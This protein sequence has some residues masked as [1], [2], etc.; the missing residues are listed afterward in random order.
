MEGECTDAMQKARMIITNKE[1]AQHLESLNRK[2]K[3]GERTRGKKIDDLQKW[4]G[5]KFLQPQMKTEL[6]PLEEQ[7][8]AQ[9]T[10]KSMDHAMWLGMGTD[11]EQLK[12]YVSNVQ[13][14]RDNV[15]DTVIGFSDQIPLWIKKGSEREVYAAWE[16]N[17]HTLKADLR[18]QLLEAFTES[19]KAKPIEEKTGQQTTAS[20][21]A[22]MKARPKPKG[23][24]LKTTSTGQTQLRANRET[25]SERYRITYEARQLLHNYYKPDEK[26]RGSVWKGLVLVQGA[27]ARLDN[28]SEDGK[29]IET[30]TY[31]YKGKTVTHKAGAP[32]GNTL[33]AMREARKKA[34]PNL[35]K[36][37]EV[38]S[39]PAA[40]VDG[41]IMKWCIES[42][43]NAMKQSVWQRDAFAAA[44]TLEAEKA[45][46]AAHQIPTTIAPK[47]TAALQLT[48]TDFARRFKAKCKHKM[49]ERR[50]RGQAELNKKGCRETWKA[51]AL[52]IITAIVEAQ[53]E[54]EEANDEEEW[55]VKGSFRNAMLMYRPNIQTGKLEATVGQEWCKGMEVG[56]TRMQMKEWLEDRMK[57]VTNGKPEPPDWKL[58]TVAKELTDLLEWDYWNPED[59]DK[60]KKII[61]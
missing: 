35:F 1:I 3:A 30:E 6:S 25:Q 50:R 7:V 60:H 45:M 33:K 39:Q 20:S 53:D 54:M 8:R 10:W 13:T 49:D 34:H 55:V 52:D 23:R 58:S 48:D 28:I 38:M 59:E 56:T 14:W 31:K 19:V 27:H 17:G 24:P 37:V 5:I 4:T 12:K 43:A 21:S 40:M 9:L 29:W 44:F 36:R 41:I 18:Q 15:Q 47:L 26:P 42:Q 22:P 57:W 2:G 46:Y 16:T 61:S 51:S 11:S 32:V